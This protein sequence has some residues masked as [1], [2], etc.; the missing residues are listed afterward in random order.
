MR[1]LWLTAL[2]GATVLCLLDSGTV[3]T[4]PV[5]AADSAGADI[6]PICTLPKC[7]NPRVTTK[8]G[9]G[10]ANA[11]AE[12]KI[13]P[14]DAA[15]W[16]ATHKPKYKL[17]VQEQVRSG[18][19]GFK[20][21][22]RANA[23]CV[24][25]RMTPIDGNTYTYAGVWEDGP[26]K[27]RPKFTTTNRQFPHTKWDETG[28]TLHP[29]GTITGWGGGSPNLA[30]QWEVLC[31]GAPAPAAKVS[32]PPAQAPQSA[33]PVPNGVQIR[34]SELQQFVTETQLQSADF[35]T[36]EATTKIAAKAGFIDVVG[37]K[38]GMP[39]KTAID[40]LKAHNPNL[41]MDPMIIPPYEALP[42]VVMTPSLFSKKY[43]ATSGPEKETVS[44]LLTMS[45]NEP[46]VWGVMREILYEK[47]DERPT[48]ETLLG[49]LRQKYGQETFK[50]V[51]T[52][53][54][55]MYDTEGQQVPETKAKEILTKCGGR[56]RIGMGK[57]MG[58]IPVQ[59][60]YFSKQVVGGYFH[61]SYGKDAFNGLCQTYSYVEAVYRGE[62][63][64]GMT[65]MIAIGVTVAAS[66]HQLE[67]SGVTASHTHLMRE[68]MALAEKRKGES[69]KRE[70]PKF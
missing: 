51:G 56:T 47:E 2:A 43:T 38:L 9:I 40:T 10:T 3:M 57:N 16:C 60:G 64:R 67:A 12:A 11:T 46:F 29:D 17:C 54:I 30:A 59:A 63:P 58:V 21:L 65:T 45:P 48:I 4:A 6:M 18:W 32:Q 39:L 14:D 25:G 70:I 28:V 31:A 44:L 37:V 42:G 55:W 69:S 52:G 26:G 22:Y 19:V 8:S 49:G 1:S 23:D 53:L 62:I 5:S 24:A 33:P 68:A 27:G 35:G 20:G 50:D 13:H 66:N 7:L 36:P 41:T 61:S 34:P 15:K